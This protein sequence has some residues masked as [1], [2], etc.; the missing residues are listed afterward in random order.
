MGNENLNDWDGFLGSNF[1]SVDDVNDENHEFV[2]IGV[3]LDTE[4]NRPIC[5]LE[6]NGCERKFSLNVTNAN[7][8]KNAEIN[9]PKE[10]IGKV[11][12]FK[13][14]LVRNP[15]TRKEVEGLRIKTIK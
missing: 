13:K 2:I 5:I 12:T 1:L 6:S 7:F 14:V 3:E 15:K 4:N 10:M 11:I 8:V 9:S